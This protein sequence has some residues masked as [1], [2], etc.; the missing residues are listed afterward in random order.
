MATEGPMQNL[1]FQWSKEVRHCSN[2]P[3]LCGHL[4]DFAVPPIM[5][6]RSH[7]MLKCFSSHVVLLSRRHTVKGSTNAGPPTSGILYPGV[8]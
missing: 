4:Q 7:T 5:G 2:R 3:R 1:C 8:Q 6:P